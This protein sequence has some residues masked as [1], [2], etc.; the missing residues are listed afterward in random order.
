MTEMPNNVP[1]V[2]QKNTKPQNSTQPDL[3]DLDEIHQNKIL[4]DQYDNQ[5]EISSDNEVEPVVPKK[6]KLDFGKFGQ[7]KLWKCAI[8]PHPPQLNYN[9]RNSNLKC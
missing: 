9:M 5:G 8:C 6:P 7:M 1:E 4:V 2:S 3:P